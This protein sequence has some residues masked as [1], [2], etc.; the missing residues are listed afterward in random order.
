MTWLRIGTVICALVVICTVAIDDAD[1]RRRSKRKRKK[2]WRHFVIDGRKATKGGDCK[3]AVASFDVALKMPRMSKRT[4]KYIE[5]LR[6]PCWAKLEAERTRG[7]LTPNE[8]AD[9]INSRSGRYTSCYMSAL[10]RNKGL[11]GRITVRVIVG[12]NG[13][14]S[15]SAVVETTL[16]SK[17]VESC[18]A[19]EIRTLRFREGTTVG[20]LYPL[21]FNS[22]G[23]SMWKDHTQK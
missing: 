22:R 1:A 8:V 10:V 17:Q 16:R 3:R 14:V 18:V 9:V 5:R 19:T 21:V 20:V 15:D 7:P 23:E 4:I 6:R 11:R 13:R 2:T 12:R